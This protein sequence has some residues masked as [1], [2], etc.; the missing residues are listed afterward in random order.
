MT[1]AVSSPQLKDSADERNPRRCFYSSATEHQEEPCADRVAARDIFQGYNLK[2]ATK[3][4]EQH[5]TTQKL[6]SYLNTTKKVARSK[7]K[8]TKIEYCCIPCW[9][10]T[11]ELEVPPK[12]L[13][14]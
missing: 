8:A 14:D 9:C 12:V 6:D 7:R 2:I 1:D 10:S 4:A 11:T 3:L 5:T 13:E